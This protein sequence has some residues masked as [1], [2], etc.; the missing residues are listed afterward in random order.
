MGGLV[1]Q[2]YLA[3]HA[4]HAAHAVPAAVL[5]LASV[6]TSSALRATLNVTRKYPP[7]F[8][9]ANATW[10][11]HLI[12]STPRRARALL[13]APGYPA[14]DLARHVARLQKRALPR[15]SRYAC[16]QPAPPQAREDAAGGA[17]RPARRH[18]HAARGKAHRP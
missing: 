3:A 5:L 9:R 1:V 13:F 6:A 15:V 12:V 8:L 7:P 4:A 14:E 18:L 11:L 17:G 2:K 16:L 10:K